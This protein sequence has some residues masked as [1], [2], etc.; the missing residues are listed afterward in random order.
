MAKPAF[1]LCFFLSHYIQLFL[2]I[3]P[4]GQGRTMLCHYHFINVIDPKSFQLYAHWATFH[5]SIIKFKIL[6]SL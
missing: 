6:I 2:S 5:S 4:H 3:S 1:H